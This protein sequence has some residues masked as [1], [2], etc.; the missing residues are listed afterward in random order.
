MYWAW[1]PGSFRIKPGGRTFF[2]G[3]YHVEW[4]RG[5]R[6]VFLGPRSTGRGTGNPT[7]KGNA[8]NKVFRIQNH[9]YYRPYKQRDAPPER[10]ETEKD[11][12]PWRNSERESLLQTRRRPRCNV[13][14]V[15]S[16]KH[17]H[18]TTDLTEGHHFRGCLWPSS[19]NSCFGSLVR[20]QGI[21]RR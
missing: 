11:S 6:G 5:S 4:S 17:T 16:F 10:N 9:W 14:G 3:Q 1:I 13:G 18:Y 7:C 12:V 20:E 19:D 2:S 21:R 15:E 8:A